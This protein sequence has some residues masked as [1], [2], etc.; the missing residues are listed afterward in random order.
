MYLYIEKDCVI[1]DKD[2]I[3]IFNLDY[4]GNT[5]EYRGLHKRL[6]EEKKITNVSEKKGKTFILTKD[7]NKEKAFFTNIG[8]YTIAKRLI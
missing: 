2:I 8:V 1:N 6:E 7:D 5:K 3:G 4:I